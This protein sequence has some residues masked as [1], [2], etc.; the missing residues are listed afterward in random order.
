MVNVL[1]E[2]RRLVS[3]K[4]YH[5]SCMGTRLCFESGQFC[6]LK[7]L[8]I[9]HLPNLF[10]LIF[11]SGAPKKLEKLTLYLVKVE[12]RNTSITGIEK[13]QKLREVEFFGTNDDRVVEK[14]RREAANMLPNPP[15]VTI[16]DQPPPP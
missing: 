7:Q 14:V 2:L 4:L 16:E 9:D 8:V 10:E 11:E 15:R 12:G 1:G 3:L 5:R 13:L 6:K